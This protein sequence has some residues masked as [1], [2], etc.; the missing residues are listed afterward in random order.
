M[1]L[2]YNTV[3][4]NNPGKLT[5]P[6]FK[7]LAPLVAFIAVGCTSPKFKDESGISIKGL[8]IEQIEEKHREMVQREY[9]QDP[10]RVHVKK[11]DRICVSYCDSNPEDGD[12]P[13]NYSRKA[14]V[15]D[16]SDGDRYHKYA[17]TADG[18][19]IWEGIGNDQKRFFVMRD[20]NGFPIAV[21]EVRKQGD[22][23]VSWEI[24][25]DNAL[26]IWNGA[27]VDLMHVPLSLGM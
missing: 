10:F 23:W 3:R 15:V 21:K 9:K 5:I 17:Y 18:E 13:F 16:L 27:V 1:I 7:V 22:G 4:A 20:T 12:V 19:R 14:I 26:R 8:S 25:S 24:N 2:N 11:E 6:C